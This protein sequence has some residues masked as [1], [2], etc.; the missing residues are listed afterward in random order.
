MPRSDRSEL[1]ERGGRRPHVLFVNAHY[2]P[3]VASTGQHLTDLAEFLAER[4][5][6]VSVLTGRGRYVAG[7]V[8]APARETHNGVSIRRVRGTSFGRGTHLGRVVDY[9]SFYVQVLVR[10][11]AG[12]RPDGVVFLTTPPLLSFVGRLARLF[13][14]QRYGIWSMDLHPDAEFAAGM[15]D[16]RGLAGRLLEWAN[17]V[18]YRGA[19]FVI[20]LG[21]Y[22]KRRLEAKG[23]RPERTRTIHVWSR[24]EEILPTPRAEN[25]LLDELGLRDRF[26]VMY[27]GNAGIVHDFDAVLEAMRRLRDDPRIFFLFVGGG[28]QRAKI[29]E[30][31]RENGLANF[32]YREYFPRE[33]LR[34]SLPVADAHLITLRA[35][36][37]G[38]A[39]PGKLYGIMAAARPALFVGP[40]ASESADAIELGQ[41]GVVIDP[42]QVNDPAGDL[43]AILR[44]WAEDPFEAAALGAAGREAFLRRY[45][46]QE[47]CAEFEAVIRE[48]W[49]HGLVGAP[50]DPPLVVGPS[51][52]R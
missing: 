50:S 9:A 27:S 4:G 19:D 16:P 17:G 43:V 10:L 52:A 32:A 3:D 1:P 22:M 44:R 51:P 14:G 11:L 12:G 37:A 33:H 7:R 47:N 21:A 49:G 26:V 18:G 25:P 28:P 42:T 35:P 20:D 8:E 46:R 30:Y 36:F 40:R 41:C 39:V 2:H 29:E 38:I 45:E 24:V 6:A 31:A 13:R 48:T 23:V 34:Y 5:Y 15:L